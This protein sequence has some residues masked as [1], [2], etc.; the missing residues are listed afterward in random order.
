[1]GNSNLKKTLIQIKMK[2]FMR[3]KKLVSTILAS[4][5]MLVGCL[6][7]G[8]SFAQTNSKAVEMKDGKMMVVAD[9]KT[10]PMTK[11]M[12]MENGT[13]CMTNGE[14]IMKDGKKMKMK[15]GEMMD[16]NGM[17]MNHG[18]MMNHGMMSNDYVMMKDGKMIVMKDRKEMPMT[19]DMTLKNGTKCLTNGEY[20]MK[21]GKKM[22]MKEGDRMDM[23]GMMS[24]G[25]MMD[26]P[27]K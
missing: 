13:R 11:E 19:K 25:G 7:T 22:K 15:E 3:N 9:G 2:N 4:I 20:I 23:N 16:M 10:M 18:D 12:T 26:G 5:F 21:D 17:M 1:M 24:N 14:Y 8:N 27:K 6:I